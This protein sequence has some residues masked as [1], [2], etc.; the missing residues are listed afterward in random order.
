MM[1]TR[2]LVLVLNPAIDQILAVDSFTPFTK[3]LVTSGN[4]YFG[5]K[6]INA[7]YVLG[8][9]GADCQAVGFT[10]AD[11]LSAYTDKLAF[12]GVKASFIPVEGKTRENLKIVDLST[13]KDTEFNHPGF[14]IAKSDIERLFSQIENEIHHYSWLI[15]NGSLPPGAPA[16][17]YARLIDLAQSV[18]V[19][20]CLDASGEPMAIGVAA[21]PDILRGNLHELEELSGHS[22]EDNTQI[23]GE[24]VR[25]HRT[26]VHFVVVSLGS[27]GVIGFDGENILHANAPD[28]SPVSLTGAGDAMTAAFVHQISEDHS[29]SDAL[30]FS[31]A[32]ASASVLR[33]EPGDF[34][35]DDTQDLLKKIRVERLN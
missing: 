8:K 16:D 2:I 14:H 28:L 15:L 7:A 20:T 21:K 33:E 31:A 11:L 17:L 32:V 26:G 25:L 9:M 12:V 10:S 18:G 29:F 6:G 22:L 30:A 27:R 3:N 19:K 24:L 23:I 1:P 4:T 13:G 5:G 34:C 35:I